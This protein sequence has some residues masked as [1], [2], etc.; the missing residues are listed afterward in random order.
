MTERTGPSTFH[1][2]QQVTCIDAKPRETAT[3]ELSEGAVYTIAKVIGPTDAACG[4]GVQLQE[5]WADA[6][7]SGYHADRFRPAV[8]TDITIFERLLVDA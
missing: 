7:Y 4:G 1:V 3:P 8:K 6:P 2:G 5:L